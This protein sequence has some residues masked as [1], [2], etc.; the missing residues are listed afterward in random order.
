MI[1]WQEVGRVA[2]GIY[3]CDEADALTLGALHLQVVYGDADAGVPA[4]LQ[5][6]LHEYVP[7]HIKPARKPREW[8]E[9]LMWTHSRMVGFPRVMCMQNYVRMMGKFPA[10]GYTLFPVSQSHLGDGASPRVLLG[11]GC[12]DM[13]FLSRT[14]DRLQTITYM[15][16]AATTALT[17][18]R[19]LL[20]LEAGDKI[21]L[22]CAAGVGTEC[23]ALVDIYSASQAARKRRRNKAAATAN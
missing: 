21:T 18:R 4:H 20:E 13:I 12:E 3:A 15:D 23:S 9:E 5:S 6:C 7:N 17:P 11:V 22:Q 2:A 19:L 10:F 1:F 14:Y 16:I 8:A